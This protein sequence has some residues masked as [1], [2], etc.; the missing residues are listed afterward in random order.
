MRF[1]DFDFQINVK[2]SILD[3]NIS[4]IFQTA[5]QPHCNSDGFDTKK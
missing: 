5:Y 1:H 4:I 3:E 2:K